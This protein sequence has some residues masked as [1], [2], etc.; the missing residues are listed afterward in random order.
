VV[1]VSAA[2]PARGPSRAP[3]DPRGRR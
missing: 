1:D 3:R 2:A